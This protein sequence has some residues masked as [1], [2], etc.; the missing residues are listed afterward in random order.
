[1]TRAT[2]NFFNFAEEKFLPELASGRG[3]A[4]QSAVV[5]GQC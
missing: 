2:F 1:M 3:T 5:E 4:A